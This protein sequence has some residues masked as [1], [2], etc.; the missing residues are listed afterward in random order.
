MVGVLGGLALAAP[1]PPTIQ[2]GDA[3]PGN[4]QPGE[5][6]GGGSPGDFTN[7]SA[8][9]AIA[10][11]PAGLTPV[12]VFPPFATPRTVP[13]VA[14]IFS[15]DPATVRR[16]KREIDRKHGRRRPYSSGGNV[17]IPL[18]QRLW[19][20]IRC[21]RP[22]LARMFARPR[23]Q[24]S[25][26]GYYHYPGYYNRRSY[27]DDIRN[28]IRKRDTTHYY[29]PYGGYVSHYVEDYTVDSADD[30]F[31]DIDEPLYGWR[32]RVTLKEN[33]PCVLNSTCIVS[34]SNSFATNF[35]TERQTGE[36]FTSAAPPD[37]R[38]NFG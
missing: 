30:C 12:A 8:A 32:V 5:P 9:E 14:V 19:K 10:L 33:E 34:T 29:S 15:E 27:F 22:R 3:P 13:A 20:N 4:P 25:D 36:S 6:G 38:L 24:T 2:P 23:P 28:R 37:C 7:P 17:G 31:D 35:P 11:V 21:I 16:R 26:L 1:P 18:F